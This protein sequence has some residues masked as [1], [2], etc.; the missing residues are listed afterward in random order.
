ME[1]ENFNAR[2]FFE[3]NYAKNFFAVRFHYLEN[4][5][6]SIDTRERGQSWGYPMA[7]MNLPEGLG[8]L[9]SRFYYDGKLSL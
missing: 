8:K 6:I 7:L 2:A 5:L 3:S 9:T 4:E 1:N